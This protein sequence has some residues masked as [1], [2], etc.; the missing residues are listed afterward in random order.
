VLEGQVAVTVRGATTL[1]GAGRTI[2][3]PALA[4]HYFTNPTAD[5]VRLLC[6]VSPAGL[7]RYFAA[8]A[9]HV[10]SRTAPAPQ[11][12]DHDEADRRATAVALAPRYGIELI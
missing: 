10:P 7:E 2:N 8:F 11:L 6:L 5:P 9:E 12:S 1:A 4:P 3:I